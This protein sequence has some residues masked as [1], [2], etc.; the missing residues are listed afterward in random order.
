MYTKADANCSHSLLKLDQ[1]LRVFKALSY[2]CH[3][4][5]YLN[6]TCRPSVQHMGRTIC[7]HTIALIFSM[8]HLPISDLPVWSKCHTEVFCKEET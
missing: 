7:N 1:P 8:N 3:I 5:L 2:S 6:K 4:G